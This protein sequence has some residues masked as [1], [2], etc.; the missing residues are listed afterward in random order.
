MVVCHFFTDF[1]TIQ[2]ISTHHDL[3][4]HDLWVPR[5]IHDVHRDAKLLPGCIHH[6]KNGGLS[7][8]RTGYT[9]LAMLK[10]INKYNKR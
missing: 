9:E 8:A 7:Q 6:A 4:I 3:T 2:L 1:K 10:E 5:N